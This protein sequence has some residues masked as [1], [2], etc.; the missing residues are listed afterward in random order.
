MTAQASLFNPERT[1]EER[2]ESAARAFRAARPEV[3]DAFCQRARDLHDVHGFPRYS[4]KG[5][6]EQLR[7]DLIRRGEDG[8]LNNNHVRFWSRWAMAEGVVPD[9]FFL[10]RDR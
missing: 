1:R 7:W 5:I 4:A 2:M 3:W 9:G 10:T 8:S 6:W